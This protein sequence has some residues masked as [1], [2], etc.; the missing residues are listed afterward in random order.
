MSL[1]LPQ[2]QRDLSQSLSLGSV[3]AQSSFGGPSRAGAVR[4]GSWWFGS[5]WLGFCQV[6]WSPVRL[7]DWDRL[8]RK[9]VC[10]VEAFVWSHG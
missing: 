3:N 7:F 5:V 10:M 4:L 6:W 8:A 1:E 2:V 9:F